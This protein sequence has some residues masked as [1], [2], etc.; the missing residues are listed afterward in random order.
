MLVFQEC[1]EIVM[2]SEKRQKMML[3]AAAVLCIGA[4]SYWY[5]G[6]DHEESRSVTLADNEV[7]RKPRPTAETPT[8]SRKPP[9]APTSAESPT[10]TA[11]KP[12]PEPP[13]P[14]TGRKPR[15]RPDKAG[16]KPIRQP[17]G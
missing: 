5:L 1:Q 3:L 4:G 15:P 14:N 12:P 6:R 11:R 13:D 16:Q 9:P 10:V 8:P 17:A 7:V 2:E